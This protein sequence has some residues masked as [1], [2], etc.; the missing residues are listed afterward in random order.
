MTYVPDTSQHGRN[1]Y[2]MRLYV[3]F[4]RLYAEIKQMYVSGEHAGSK[5]QSMTSTGDWIETHTRSVKAADRRHSYN[6]LFNTLPECALSY[7]VQLLVLA[8]FIAER[9]VQV[10]VILL[11]TAHHLPVISCTPRLGLFTPARPDNLPDVP[12]PVTCW[13]LIYPQPHIKLTNHW[14]NW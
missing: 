6:P 1:T 4:T 5:F 11:A 10:L 12:S 7:L 3:L 13:P 2:Q 14:T 9:E 8:D